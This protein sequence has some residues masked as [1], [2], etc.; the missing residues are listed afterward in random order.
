MANA[1]D[2]VAHHGLC[3]S[4]F[5]FFQG[6]T[7]HFTNGVVDLLQLAWKILLSINLSHISNLFFSFRGHLVNSWWKNSKRKNNKLR[8]QTQISPNKSIHKHTFALALPFFFYSVQNAATEEEGQQTRGLKGESDVLNQSE[9]EEKEALPCSWAWQ[10]DSSS[11]RRAAAPTRDS[12]LFIFSSSASAARAW[13]LR[14]E[15][16]EAVRVPQQPG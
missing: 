11:V 4:I 12:P 14:E 3:L 13:K 16:K 6:Q 10:E 2:M 1:L 9:E 7:A 15:A 5:N 8:L